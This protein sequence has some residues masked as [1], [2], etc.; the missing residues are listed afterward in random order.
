MRIILSFLALLLCVNIAISTSAQI[1]CGAER[2]GLY[3]YELKEKKVGLVANQSSRVNNQHLLDF[4]IDNDIRVEKIFTPEHGFRGDA[5][6]GELITDG[7]DSKTGIPIIS[8]Y[9]KNKK[10]S[11][12]MFSE[13]DIV[14]FDMQD[15]GVRF[16]TYYCTMF[17]VMQTCAETN[18]KLIVLDRPNPNGDYVAGPVL[19]MKHKSFIGLLPIPVVHGCTLGEL[20]QMINGEGW[21]ENDLQCNLQVVKVD[22]YTHQTPYDLPIK[23]SPNLPN[24]TAIRLY[25]SLCFFEATTM[26]VGRGTDFPFQVIG[27]PDSTMGNFC[28]TPRSIPGMAKNP[29]LE[30]K[31]CYGIDYRLA[32]EEHK[33]TLEPFIEYYHKFE[34]QN[35]FVDRVNWFTLLIG[36][37]K[38]LDMIANGASWEELE[39]SWTNELNAYK[40]MRKRYLLYPDSSSN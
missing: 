25:P 6:A 28:F 22:N 8:L 18:T 11:K 35:D 23:P 13:L 5:D 10:P 29:K 39:Q 24:S 36:N 38:T 26:S 32:S 19:D 7:K 4:L 34:K 2:S 12:Q 37:E 20:A 14:V 16:Y 15:V 33:F 31:L 9:G 1:R 3:I 21:L 27:Y 17:Y 40:K 30:G